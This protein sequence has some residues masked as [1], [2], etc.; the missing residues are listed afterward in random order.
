MT[1][2]AAITPSYEPDFG[3]CKELSR[4]LLE[5]SSE[6]VHDHII[7]PRRD[8]KLFARLAGQRRHI[9]CEAE[10]LPSSFVPV[11]F[12]KFTV[13]LRRPFPPVRGWILQQVLKLAAAAAVHDDAVVLV[14]SDIEFHS[15]VHSG[16]VCETGVVRFYRNPKC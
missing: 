11:P 9:R 2:L 6:T 13:N 4:S 7:A 10:S 15:A 12:S 5:N 8:L 1:R 14:D 16:D 3:L